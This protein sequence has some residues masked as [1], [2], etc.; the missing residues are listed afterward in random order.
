MMIPRNPTTGDEATTIT[1][2]V[3]GIMTNG[4][5]LDSHSQTWSYDMCNGH[6]DTKHQYHYHIP[7]ICYLKS[8]GVS[9]PDSENWWINDE[10]DAVRPYEEMAAQFP[11]TGSS[12]ILGFARD[13][14][15]I[16]ALYDSSGSLV[17]SAAFDGDL[18]ECNGKTDDDG[19]AYYITSEPPFV[20][21]CLWG[22]VGSFTAVQTQLACPKDGITNTIEGV[23]TDTLTDGGTIDEGTI[24]EGTGEPIDEETDE[25]V[26]EGDSPAEAS[27]DSHASAPS[28]ET[29]VTVAAAAAFFV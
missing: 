28:L 16:K 5:L 8:M 24:D 19:Y 17:R 25:V 18:D 7:P 2:D 22:D 29:F 4:V 14:H 20:P 3:V 1:D 6:S 27:S 21:T 26:T 15:P 11:E 10:M 12:P 23:S 9:T 13:G